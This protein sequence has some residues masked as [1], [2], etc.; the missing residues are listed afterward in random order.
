LHENDFIMV[1]ARCRS[2]DYAKCSKIISCR[3]LTLPEAR[4]SWMQRCTR[5]VRAGSGEPNSTPAGGPR[6]QT[7]RT[8]P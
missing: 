3:A 6:A 5:P 1:L 4:F 2:T 8:S 7:A